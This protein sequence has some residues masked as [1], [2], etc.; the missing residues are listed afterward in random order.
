LSQYPARELGRI[1]EVKIGRQRSPKHQEGPHLVPY[2][3]AANV[4]DGVVNIGDLLEMNFSPAEQDSYGLRVGDVLVTEGCGSPTELGASAQWRGAPAAVVCYQNH[5][6]RLRAIAGVSDPAYLAQLARWCQRTGRWL[7][8]S[9]GTGI[10]NIG[11]GRAQGMLVPA[12]PVEV[13][14]K[15][16][17]I[18]S[19]YDDLIE[20]HN[21]RIMLLEEIAR[22]IY[23]EWFVELRYLGHENIPLVDS[24]L[25]LVPEGW[26]VCALKSIAETI[27]RGVSPRYADDSTQL[28]INQK[29]IRNG[30]LDIA[31]ARRHV[32]P[33]PTVKMVRFG[34][35]LINST[36]VGTLGR[37]AQVLLPVEGVTVDSHVTIVR[38]ATDVAETEFVGLMLLAREE[39][40]AAM[41]VGSTGQTELSR[42]AVGETKV[43]LPP[44]QVQ[45]DFA[46]A[47]RGLRR[48]PVSLAM[49]SSHLRASRD[50]LLPRLL[51]GEIDVTD[52]DIDAMDLAA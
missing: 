47:V 52:L 7:S 29:C 41:G 44:R 42:G 39:E 32:S 31:L 17:R 4:K 16:G 45:S 11:Q 22:R 50:L 18:L 28:V 20:N 21:R 25:G 6:L 14:Q 19:A 12:P 23:S 33:V 15:I 1:C 30:R 38:A 10:L 36:G 27:A 3:R 26:T 9:S 51:S 46:D 8:V 35:I 2:V 24:E 48:L 40:F 43:V 37:V 49:A 5:L 13:Q 34:D